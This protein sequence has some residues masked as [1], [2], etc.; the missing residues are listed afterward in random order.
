LLTRSCI[1]VRILGGV[2][3]AFPNDETNPKT[4]LTDPHIWNG[5]WIDESRVVLKYKLDS[6]QLFQPTW[7]YSI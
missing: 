5:S 3:K 4:D 6:W 2:A 7:A 1:D